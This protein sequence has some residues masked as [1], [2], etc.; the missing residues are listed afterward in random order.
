MRNDGK[1]YYKIETSTRGF[2]W[3]RYSSCHRLFRRLD[4]VFPKRLLKP[5]PAKTFMLKTLPDNQLEERRKG[6]DEFFSQVMKDPILSQANQVI[7]FF[8]VIHEQ[9]AIPKAFVHQTLEQQDKVSL[10]KTEIAHL[11]TESYVEEDLNLIRFLK[12]RKWDVAKAAQAVEKTINWRKSFG[13]E[14]LLRDHRK[15]LLRE[16]ETGKSY[17][18]DFTDKTGRTILCLTPELENTFDHEGNLKALV[19]NLERA[20][21]EA[22]VVEL[23]ITLVIDFKNY[24]IRNAPPLKTTRATID[25][26]QNHF[27]ELLNKAILINAPWLFHQSFK[28]IQPLLD[29][30]TK[31]KIVFADGLEEWIAKPLLDEKFQVEKYLETKT[32]QA[33]RAG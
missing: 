5:F 17:V 1:V 14:T 27:V 28:L 19:Y 26:L 23:P 31:S 18:A 9:E 20:R 33:G 29:P 15:T 24:S 16:L 3:R 25:I 2:I 10:L 7:E 11:A 32:N 12:A 8:Q 22:K 21:K 6:L 13:V 30:A 4:E